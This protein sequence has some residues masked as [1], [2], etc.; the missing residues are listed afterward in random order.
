MCKALARPGLT[1][2]KTA[3]RHGRGPPT[4]PKRAPRRQRLIGVIP[5][6]RWQTTTFLGALRPDGL[7]AP[8]V[9]DGAIIAADKRNTHKVAGVREAIEER[10][11]TTTISRLVLASTG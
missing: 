2:E 1:L 11:A 5:H 4:S 8:L 10:G 3:A 7:V 9:L 6:G